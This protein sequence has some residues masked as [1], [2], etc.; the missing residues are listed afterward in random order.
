MIDDVGP[1]VT[2]VAPPATV[3]NRELKDGHSPS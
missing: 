1:G 3:L 2:V